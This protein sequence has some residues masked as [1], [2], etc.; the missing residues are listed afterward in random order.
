MIHVSALHVDDSSISASRPA[1][2]FEDGIARRSG[3]AFEDVVGKTTSLTTASFRVFLRTAFS[4]DKLS[5]IHKQPQEIS[6]Y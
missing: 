1:G 5:V 3:D 6:R 4:E 2:H